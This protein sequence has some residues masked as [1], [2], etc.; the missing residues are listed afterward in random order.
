M[1]CYYMF[2][3]YLL[4]PLVINKLIYLYSCI[5]LF[6][7]GSGI[8]YAIIECMVRRIRLHIHML[9]GSAMPMPLA[10]N[11]PFRRKTMLVRI[12]QAA[13]K[14]GK[15]PHGAHKDGNILFSHTFTPFLHI[16]YTIFCN[17]TT[18]T[19]SSSQKYK[20]IPPHGIIRRN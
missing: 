2:C 10:V 8:T 1:F 17:I 4:F 9:A 7:K 16:S 18:N 11:G 3:F 14:Q 19:A 15:H 13:G 6:R 20:N 12:L 5:S